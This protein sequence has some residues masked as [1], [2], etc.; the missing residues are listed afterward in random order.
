MN[1]TDLETPVAVVDLDRLTANIER[2]QVYLDEHGIANRPHI[3]THKI[4]E[5]AWM[6]LR[7]G[8]V[9]ITCRNSARRG[10]GRDRHPGPFSTLQYCG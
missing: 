2:L 4:P 7:R 3:K 8:A 1:I 5:I 9:G 6:Q 10:D